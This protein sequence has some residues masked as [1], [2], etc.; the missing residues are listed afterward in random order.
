M[1]IYEYRCEPCHHS[2][3]VFLA[4]SGEQAVCPKCH[5]V[6]LQR[7]L[8]TFSASV[9]GGY[10]ASQA[11]SPSSTGS[12]PPAPSGGCGGGCSCH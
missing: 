4:T 11:V 12:V 3:E 6:R 9:P 5:G 10:K 1:P 7:L 2:F 8:S